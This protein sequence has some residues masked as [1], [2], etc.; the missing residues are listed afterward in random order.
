M[1]VRRRLSLLAGLTGLASCALPERE[2][3]A[4]QIVASSDVVLRIEP[5][6]EDTLPAQLLGWTLGI[7]GVQL[8]LLALDVEE[9]KTWTTASAADGR[10][11]IADLPRGRYR[12]NGKRL[13]T[14]TERAQLGSRSDAVAYVGSHELT[15]GTAAGPEYSV[16]LPSAHR[17]GLVLSEDTFQRAMV[18]GFGTYFY[19]GYLELYNNGTETVYLDGLQLAQAVAYPGH[20]A[21]AIEPCAVAMPRHVDPSGISTQYLVKFPGS[22]TTFPVAPG[23]AVV[24]AMDG[25]DHR[26]LFP[27]MLDLSGADFEMPGGPDNPAIPDMIDL[28]IRANVLHTHGPLFDG[29]QAAT[30]V[31]ALPGNPDGY[32]RVNSTNFVFMRV[33]ARQILDVYTTSSRRFRDDPPAG[34]S[35]CPQMVHPSFDRGFAWLVELGDYEYTVARTRRVLFVDEN[36]VPVLQHTRWSEQDWERAERTPGRIVP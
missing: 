36:G 6:L 13:L 23:N 30:Q 31:L 35:I 9:P 16:P 2:L 26:N 5:L 11:Q 17:R 14:A 21:G 12:V 10:A 4:P 8:E 3:T 18:P 34:Y 19:G 1:R 24:V 15:I 22:G 29:A 33:P 20:L 27:R 25:V 32:Q 7:P 28:S